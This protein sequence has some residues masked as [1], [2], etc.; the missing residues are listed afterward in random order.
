MQ[1]QETS[2]STGNSQPEVIQEKAD[3]NS[4]EGTNPVDSAS[5]PQKTVTESESSNQEKT[6]SESAAPELSEEEKARL[7][8]RR[9]SMLWGYMNITKPS[10]V[11]LRLFLHHLQLTIDPVTSLT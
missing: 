10:K 7:K 8:K 2:N 11:S 3:E 4:E 6:K 5:D 9:Q 1:Q